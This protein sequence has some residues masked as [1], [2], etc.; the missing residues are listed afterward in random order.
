MRMTVICL[1]DRNTSAKIKGWPM[2]LVRAFKPH[3]WSGGLIA[4]TQLLQLLLH[5]RVVDPVASGEAPL[6]ALLRSQV[7][8]LQLCQLGFCTSARHLS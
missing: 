4:D 1:Y 3:V 2:R 5:L 7:P 6:H 8:T